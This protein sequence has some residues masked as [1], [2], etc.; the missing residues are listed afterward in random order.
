MM[1]MMMTE[2]IVLKHQRCSI[3]LVDSRSVIASGST[4]WLSAAGSVPG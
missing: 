1:M 4:S 2:S 3:R